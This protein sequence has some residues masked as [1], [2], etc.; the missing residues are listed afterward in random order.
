MKIRNKSPK[1]EVISNSVIDDVE[2]HLDAL[3][4]S[5]PV[6][7]EK[8]FTSLPVDTIAKLTNPRKI[9]C[10]L[11]DFRKVEWPDLDNEFGKDELRNALVSAVESFPWYEGLSKSEQESAIT[12]FEGIHALALSIYKSSQSQP[13][14]LD[15]ESPASSIAF[16]VAGERRVLSCIYSRGKVKTVE[17][18]VFNRR[19]SKLE[20]AVYTHTENLKVGLSFPET[21]RATYDVWCA[22]DDPASMSLSELNGYW[23][24]GSLSTPSI[25]KRVFLRDDAEDV[26]STVAKK[27]LSVRDIIAFLDNP[28][29]GLAPRVD[30]P[31]DKK[32]PVVADAERYG[33]K[34]DK[35][36]QVKVASYILNLL[37]SANHL[38]S[39]LGDELSKAELS[40]KEGLAAAWSAIAKIAVEDGSDA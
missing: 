1:R 31:K 29:A 12:F 39:S 14:I 35:S 10:T 30:R 19:L 8:V 13:V 16:L 33:L 36:Q 9:P 6:A 18:V 15:R 2:V 28:A 26:V 20:R 32:A 17:A 37:S 4:T 7:E 22:L 25:L 38:P 3:K 23:G 5:A 21:L 27:N 24:Y 11:D 40:S 34:L